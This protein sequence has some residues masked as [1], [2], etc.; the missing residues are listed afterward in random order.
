MRRQTK[1]LRRG[2]GARRNDD[3]TLPAEIP[4]V[5]RGPVQDAAREGAP[6]STVATTSPTD[7][8]EETIRR[9][10]EAAYT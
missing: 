10:L 8:D 5:S 3:T 9:M 2:V 7:L 6:Q 4:V 1:P